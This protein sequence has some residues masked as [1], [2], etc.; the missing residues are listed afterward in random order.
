MSKH[1]I[2]M[3]ATATATAITLLGAAF[4]TNG[5]A[6]DVKLPDAPIKMVAGFAA[7]GS[8]DVFTR[9][10]GQHM[11]KTLQR[12]IIVENK[13][14]AG[15]RTASYDVSRADPDGTTL[16]VANISNGVLI[17]L[18]FSDAKYHPLKDFTPIGT[19]A[20]FQ[21]A[22]ATGP[23]TNTKDLKSLLAWMKSNPDK[24]VY[25]VPGLGSIPH[26]YG[27]QLEKSQAIDMRM[28][29]MRGGAPITNDLLAGQIPM[30]IA[31]TADFAE[32]HRSDRIKIVAVSGTKRAPGF[33]DV[34]TFAEQGFPGFESNGWI[35]VFAPKGMAKN[36]QDLFADAVNKALGDPH[37]QSRLISLGMIPKP[38][39]PADLVAQIERDIAK[40]EPLIEA[41]GIKK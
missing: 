17:P 4:A 3:F 10:I 9:L 31:G 26:L 40:W 5:S 30:G 12:T 7:G 28:L 21:I 25:A 15:G 14:G 29:Q 32:L 16:L 36:L 19:G 23:M 2:A 38:G 1:R 35:A 34:P 13:A 33:D 22:F 8:A 27:L 11:E 24:A 37:V 6:Q 20:D 41:A 18:T 39:T